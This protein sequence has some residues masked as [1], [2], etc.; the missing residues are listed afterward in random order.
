MKAVAALLAQDLKLLLRNALFWVVTASL[1]V[2]VLT[3]RLLI[4]AD[5]GM[6]R[7]AV[8]VHGLGFPVPGALEM[9]SAADVEKAVAAGDAVGL[10][11]DGRTVTLLHGGL[12]ERAAAA[13]AALLLPAE[14]A[15]PDVAVET[16]RPGAPA[17]AANLRLTPM[18]ICFEAVVL[19]FLLSAVLMLNERREQVLRAFRVSPGGA[20]RYVLAKTALFTCA[21]TLYAALMAAGTVG[22]RFDWPAFIALA[23]MMSALYTLLGMCLAVF[24]RDI[25]GWFFTALTVLALNMLP[26]VSYGAPSFAPAWITAIPS[27][28]SLFAMEE[29]LFPTGRAIAGTLALLG[30]EAAAAFA[31][32]VA[33]VR[34]KLLRAGREV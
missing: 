28:P 15:T 9:G 34:W 18:F 17:V 20:A 6:G 5:F 16:L 21:G 27:Y 2:I 22:L 33:L 30:M 1:A 7:E 24:F 13:L 19:G 10:V 25:S 14:P 29:A 4:P 23:A 31:L 8:A 11:A 12:D 26:M 3:V 32:C